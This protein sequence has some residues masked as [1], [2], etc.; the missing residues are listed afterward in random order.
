MML[1]GIYF[2][3]K[4]IVDPSDEHILNDALGGRLS[5]PDRWHPASRPPRSTHAAQ[6]CPERAGRH[7]LAR[8]RMCQSGGRRRPSSRRL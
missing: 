2:P 4:P 5:S 6:A 7:L 1:Y 8:L 3:N